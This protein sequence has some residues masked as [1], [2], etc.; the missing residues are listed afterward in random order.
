MYIIIIICVTVYNK[1]LWYGKNTLNY[2]FIWG[3]NTLLYPAKLLMDSLKIYKLL[4]N[5][6][7]NKLCYNKK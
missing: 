3:E 1:F 7:G 4:Y 5:N 6:T 2:N